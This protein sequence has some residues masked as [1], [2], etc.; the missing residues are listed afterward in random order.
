ML[1]MRLLRAKE[2]RLLRSLFQV[3]LLT[4]VVFFALIVEWVGLT[5]SIV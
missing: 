1:Q 3:D 5:A 2:G 4:V